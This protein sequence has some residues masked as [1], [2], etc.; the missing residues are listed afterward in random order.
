MASL[1]DGSVYK[2]RHGI[3]MSFSNR[4]APLLEA[5]QR[6]LLQLGYKPSSISSHQVYLTRRTQLM[7]FFEEIRPKNPKHVE[8]YENFCVGSPVGSGS[9]L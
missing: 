4:S 6:V 2:L 1:T 5:L 8:R 3:Q 7:R 9:G